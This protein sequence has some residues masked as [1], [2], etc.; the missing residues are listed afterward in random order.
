MVTIDGQELQQ[1]ATWAKTTL[2]SAND[3]LEDAT[4]TT[5]KLLLNF[6]FKTSEYVQLGFIYGI[7]SSK[8]E[9]DGNTVVDSNDRYIGFKGIYNFH[10]QFKFAYYMALTILQL[11]TT[12]NKTSKSDQIVYTTFEFGKRIR[13]IDFFM[14]PNV[15]Y[16]PSVEYSLL[17]LSGDTYD[18]NF[19]TGSELRINALQF[20]ILW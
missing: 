18:G 13:M 1:A 14:G 5:T 7:G 15:S 17:N 8:G 11:S 3:G 9:S 19:E 2:V 6:S 20:D 16:S 12:N 4:T 10:E